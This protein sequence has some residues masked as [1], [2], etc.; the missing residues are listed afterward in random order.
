MAPAGAVSADPPP[1]RDGPRPPAGGGA[2]PDDLQPRS[3][4]RRRRGPAGA[5]AAAPPPWRDGLV[6]TVGEGVLTEHLHELLHCVVSAPGDDVVMGG[7]V[8]GR[9]RR[10][11]AGGRCFVPQLL[12]PGAAP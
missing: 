8:R 10:R 5:V 12:R 1:W 2:P 4:G 6:P 9:G 11:Q 7:V 3:P